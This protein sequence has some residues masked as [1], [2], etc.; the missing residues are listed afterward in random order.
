MAKMKTEEE[1]RDYLV[2]LFKR[3]FGSPEGQI[4]LTYILDDLF[5][6]TRP[7]DQEGEAR[8]NYATELLHD[9]LG[10]TDSIAVTAA[11]LKS[12]GKEPKCPE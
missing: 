12:N 4:V 7:T 8:R 10:I 5:Y 1:R 6:F 2:G 3:V 11:L 9:R